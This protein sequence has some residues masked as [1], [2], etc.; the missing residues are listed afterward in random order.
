MEIYYKI[1][2]REERLPKWAQDHINSFRSAIR[3]MQ[4][5]LEQDVADSNTFLQCSYPIQDEALGNS[6]RII[7]NT[8]DPRG[9]TDKFNVHIEGDTLKIYAATTVLIKPTSSNLIEVR[10]EDRR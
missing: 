8:G 9:L 10:M 2:P 1:D 6:P 4:K 5:A 7:F 3:Q